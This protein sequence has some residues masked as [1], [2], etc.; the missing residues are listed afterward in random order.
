MPKAKD[1]KG[2]KPKRGYKRGG[3]YTQTRRFHELFAR[4]Y[5]IDMSASGA[6][7]RASNYRVTRAS[8]GVKGGQMMK[9]DEVLELIQTFMDERARRTNI[10]ADRVLEELAMLGF[11][12]VTELLTV[13]GDLR[14][15]GDIDP[16]LRKAIAGFKVVS[17]KKPGDGPAKYE[18]VTEV[19]LWDKLSAL[20]K[21]GKNLK[22]WADSKEG[23]PGTPGKDAKQMTDL[24]LA[25]WIAWKL[26]NA[27]NPTAQSGGASG[28]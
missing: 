17:K 13:D 22:L 8:A 7:M 6:Y 23:P 20:D 27:V 14:P 9:N 25:R 19:K 28:D 15:L 26:D 5:L 10:S 16:T 4:E 2:E 1:V 12:D 24:E 18:Y 21:L 3:G 11:S